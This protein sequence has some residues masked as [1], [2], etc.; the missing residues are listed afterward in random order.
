MEIISK[1]PRL[2]KLIGEEIQFRQYDNKCENYKSVKSICNHCM[3]H[4]ELPNVL[5]LTI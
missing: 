5:I 2:I 1:T 3:E 4:N